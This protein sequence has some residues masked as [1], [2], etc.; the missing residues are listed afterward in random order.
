[1]KKLMILAVIV[2]CTAV[3]AAA[4]EKFNSGNNPERSV[5]ERSFEMPQQYVN[6]RDIV[7]LPNKGK[8]IIELNNAAQYEELQHIDTLLEAVLRNIAFYK[9]SLESSGSVRI[10]YAADEKYKFSKIRFQIHRPVG[11]IFMNEPNEIS[12]LKLEQDSIRIYVKRNPVFERDVESGSGFR[13]NLTHAGMYQVT[14]CLNSYTDLASVLA[15]KGLL[16]HAID[17][18]LSTKGKRTLRNPFRR[19]SSTRF[20]PSIQETPDSKKYKNT[21]LN[22]FR[23]FE[24]LISYNSEG[25]WSITRSSDIV[26]VTGNVGIGLIRNTFAPYAEVGLDY[27]RQLKPSWW[28]NNRNVTWSLFAS[29]YFFFEKGTDNTYY[30]KPNWFINA[31]VGSGDRYSAGLGYLFDRRGDYFKGTTLKAFMNIRMFKSKGLTLS[32]ELI[33]T[34]DFKQVIPGLTIKVF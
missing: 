34:D 30:S 9:D 10:D 20:D 31:K 12:K 22:R 6:V 25:R 8:M 3:T 11:A 24:G 33:I 5:Y 7:I 29:S 32:P 1:M 28:D 14:F 19:P 23:R 21:A 15:N 4:Q 17:T 26:E 16:H 13:Y 2:L 27:E 18:L